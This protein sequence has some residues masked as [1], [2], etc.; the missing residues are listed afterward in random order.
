VVAPMQALC[1]PDCGGLCPHC[2]GNRNLGECQCDQEP[3]DPRWALL[4]ALLEA[5]ES[6]E[7]SD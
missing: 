2:G 5:D 1:R 7:R 6:D 4:Q 3:S